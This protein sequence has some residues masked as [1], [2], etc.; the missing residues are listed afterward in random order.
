[1]PV[2]GI[3]GEFRGTP[4]DGA[5]LPSRVGRCFGNRF[6]NRDDFVGYLSTNIP[7][8]L[9]ERRQNCFVPLI[10]IGSNERVL[11]IKIIIERRL[12]DPGAIDDRV[13]A[14]AADSVRVKKLLGG[15]QNALAG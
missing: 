8:S 1:R 11:V 12:G 6:K 3:G 15:G 13:D 5:T 14:D 4:H 7:C 2:L 9:S 10:E